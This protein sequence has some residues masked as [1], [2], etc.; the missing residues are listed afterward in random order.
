MEDFKV[1]ELKAVRKE[2]G[3]H[4]S[5]LK[6]AELKRGVPTGITENLLAGKY[7]AFYLL[8]DVVILIPVN[9]E[10]FPIEYSNK[11]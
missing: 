10:D 5:A 6:G 9:P 8:N 4:F 1:V 11:K 2:S 3:F 7:V